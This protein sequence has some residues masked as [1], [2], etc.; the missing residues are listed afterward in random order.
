M[1]AFPEQR[2]S[3][4]TLGVTS[5]EA[6]RAFYEGILGFKPFMTDKIVMYNL[7]SI[8]FGLWERGKLHEDIGLMGN[9]CPP[10]ICPNFAIAYN[11]RSEAE[12]DAIFERLKAAEVEI[13]KP[14]HKADW[15]G[16]SGYFLDP[17]NNAWEAVYN[18]FWKLTE[19][20]APQMPE[21]VSG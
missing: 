21:V 3:I 17:D 1:S 5:V 12:V 13:T 4:I 9:T 18:P 15:G 8:A 11:T 20:G 6:S 19:K 7:G 2:F 10:G 16:Y 14:P